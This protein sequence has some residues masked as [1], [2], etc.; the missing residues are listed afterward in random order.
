MN[1]LQGRIWGPLVLV[2]I[3]FIPVFFDLFRGGSSKEDKVI[4]VSFFLVLFAVVLILM[5]VTFG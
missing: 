4:W 5:T 3:G 1:S 2:L